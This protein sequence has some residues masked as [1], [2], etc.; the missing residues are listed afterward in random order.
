MENNRNKRIHVK[1]MIVP[2]F[3]LFCVMVNAAKINYFMF[4]VVH[5]CISFMDVMHD[6]H[7]FTERKSMKLPLCT[8][9]L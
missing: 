6:A 7:N 9:Y 8:S 4:S 1:I 5:I 3:I 2:G